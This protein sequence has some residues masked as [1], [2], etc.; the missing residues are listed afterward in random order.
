M[1][2]L[3]SAML[4]PCV[5]IPQSEKSEKARSDSGE[6]GEEAAFAGDSE[7][8]GRCEIIRGGTVYLSPDED[9]TRE[10]QIIYPAVKYILGGC[11]L[12]RRE[13]LI[14]VKSGIK[15]ILIFSFESERKVSEYAARTA[16]I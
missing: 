7:I 12:I 8:G 9:I 2:A 13:K 11:R 1:T 10:I 16:E 14:S 6:Y 4:K 5:F 3:L 15:E